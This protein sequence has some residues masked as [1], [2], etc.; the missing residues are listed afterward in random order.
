VAGSGPDMD[1]L[2]A[3]LARLNEILLGP[4]AYAITASR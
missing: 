1:I 4:T 2:N 3:N